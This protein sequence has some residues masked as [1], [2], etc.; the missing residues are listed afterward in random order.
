MDKNTIQKRYIQIT[1]SVKSRKLKRAFELLRELV[2]V[3]GNADYQ[4][5]LDNEEFNYENILKYTI[6]GVDDPA[7]DKVYQHVMTSLLELGDVVFMDLMIDKRSSFYYSL[8]KKVLQRPVLSQ[9]EARQIVD[10]LSFQEE[11][12]DVLGDIP[13]SASG[14]EQKLKYTITDV[15][16]QLWLTDKYS[17]VEET[18]AKSIFTNEYISWYDKCLLVTS[19]TLSLLRCFDS[20]KFNLLFDVSQA[21]EDEIWQR[22]FFGVV[23]GLYKYDQRLELYPEITE[24]LYQL[25]EMPG[26][27]ENIEAV[28]LQLIKSK[29][30][31]KIS[32]T[33]QEE[34]IPE[35]MKFKPRIEDKLDLED[36]VADD[37]SEDKNPN[38]EKFFED[39]PELMDKL[40]KFSEWQLEGADVFMSAFAM[41][42]FFPFFDNMTNWLVPFYAYQKDL[43]KA[44]ASEN[45]EIKGSDFLD[46]LQKATHMC[47]SDKYSFLLNIPMMPQAQKDMISKFFT[48]ELEQISDISQQDQLVDA[49]AKS[50][51][52]FTQ[53]I[54]DLYRFFKLNRNR[55]DF[56]DV[57]DMELDLYNTSFYKILVDDVKVIRRVGEYC[58]EKEHYQKAESIY[59]GMIE[60]GEVDNEVYEKVGFCNQ[61]MENYEKAI[62][63][64]NK[65]ELFDTNREWTL[66]KLAFCHRKLGRNKEAL[67]Y[68]LQLEKMHPENTH[69]LALTGNCYLDLKNYAKALKCYYKVE[70]LKPDNIRIMRPIAWCSFILGK[71]GE[72]RRYYEKLMMENP[73][74]FDLMNFGHLELVEGNRSAAINLYIQ[75]LSKKENN[76]K[77]FLSGFQDDTAFLLQHGILEADISILLDYLQYQNK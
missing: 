49:S 41:L 42:K 55:G 2:R 27:I 12:D 7:R 43:Q 47:N 29:E 58:F 10:D 65:A 67:K 20:R 50:R 32:R 37:F 31:E 60:V 66:K 23:I 74:H 72:S 64:Y 19:I 69:I 39:S 4:D 48:S 1:Q 52:I 70:F 73:T 8:K 76:L 22:A 21:A 77:M 14:E 18:L 44:L 6:M 3:T 38:W 57:F 62:A 40:Q 28:I 36:L 16:N 51:V 13:L 71:F 26:I 35:M 53:Y 46:G 33:M 61:K 45:Q 24:R 59:L 5:R 25:K 15:F 75:S 34:I 11:I 56:E 68:Y 54:Q 9:K 63:F 17:E 30:T